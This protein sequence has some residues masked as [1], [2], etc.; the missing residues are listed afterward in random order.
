MTQALVDRGGSR[1]AKDKGIPGNLTSLSQP[2]LM[3]GQAGRGLTN[4]M[5]SFAGV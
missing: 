1:I 4:Q 3:R 2:R 5:P